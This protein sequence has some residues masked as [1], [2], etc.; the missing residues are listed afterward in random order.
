MS[1]LA[2]VPG[3]RVLLV[4]DEPNMARTLAKILERKGYD[5]AT[6]GNGE[7]AL[8]LESGGNLPCS[9]SKE[10]VG[11]EKGDLTELV[12]DRV[13]HPTLQPSSPQ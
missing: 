3:T 5:V 1:E 13:V 9:A 10:G 8:L 7:E 11:I 2:A 6:A 12:G 4:E